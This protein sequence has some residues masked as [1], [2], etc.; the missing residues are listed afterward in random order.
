MSKINV[1]VIGFGHLGSKHAQ[2]YTSFDNV[3]LK[4]ACDTDESKLQKIS[5]DC[6][7]K[8]Y[9]DYRKLI[10]EEDIQAA[11]ICV[12]TELHYQIAKDC[13][14]KNIHVLVEKPVTNT[15]K[16]AD[17]LLK[18]AKRRKLIFQVGHVER[19]NSA[20]QAVQEL[21]KKPLFIECHRLSPFPGRSLDIGVVLDLMIHDI[22]IIL[23]LVRS[24][25]KHIDAVG[26][27]VLT[28]YED[29][30]NVRINFQNGCV[31]NLT[32]SRV[33]DETMR[34]IRIFVKDTYISLD[35]VKQEAFIYRKE[36]D[37]IT[38]QQMQI[39]KEQPLQKELGDFIN[40]VVTNHKPVVSGLE[41][42]EAL[43]LAIKI[44]NQIWRR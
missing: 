24:K 28:Q 42:R 1:A 3:N 16:Q 6:G 18:L 10:S 40:C 5:S 41:A 39:E 31:C 25:P 12:P 2:I 15:V 19:F 37:K 11:S 7:A 14:Q 44:K 20:F 23:G 22:D 43:D 13:L 33:S 9:L 38:C 32:A 21:V 34:K 36:S 27:N 8:P 30:A 29:I 35:Y 4:A 17:E 26:V